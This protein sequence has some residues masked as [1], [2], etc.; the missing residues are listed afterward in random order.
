M[1]GIFREITRENA[2]L[3]KLGG[4]K[5]GATVVRVITSLCKR[6]LRLKSCQAVRVAK[7]V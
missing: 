6:S 2:K 7:E 3:V 1:L 4:N 5:Y